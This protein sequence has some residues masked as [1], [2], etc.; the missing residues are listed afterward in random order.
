MSLHFARWRSILIKEQKLQTVGR[1]DP[2]VCAVR[3]CFLSCSSKELNFDLHNPKQDPFWD[4]MDANAASAPG[5]ISSLELMIEAS[6]NSVLDRRFGPAADT[7]DAQIQAAVAA[8][9]DKRLGPTVGSLGNR[10]TSLIEQRLGNAVGIVNHRVEKAIAAALGQRLGPAGSVLTAQI[11]FT[12][13]S[14]SGLPSVQS[15]AQVLGEADEM[16]EDNAICQAAEQ[17]ANAQPV[18]TYGSKEQEAPKEKKNVTELEAYKMP[19]PDSVDEISFHAANSEKSNEPTGKKTWTTHCD[20]HKTA[21]YPLF[22]DSVSKGRNSATEALTAK[23]SRTSQ[24]SS[25]SADQILA[26]RKAKGKDEAN[27]VGAPDE[28]DSL[29]A[30]E[31]ESKNEKPKRKRPKVKLDPPGYTKGPAVKFRRISPK[32]TASTKS[33]GFPRVIELKEFSE[34]SNKENLTM[35]DVVATLLYNYH[36]RSLEA[37]ID[38]DNYPTFRFI[39]KESDRKARN[40]VIERHR[41]SYGVVVKVSGIQLAWSR[42]LIQ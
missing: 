17:L 21:L 13:A 6:V 23:P 9:L 33:R 10:M 12:P 22:A 16:K 7:L 31:E 42:E 3:G 32:L 26:K 25:S 24:R 18:E 11:T 35:A 8:A 19:T 2:A 41:E 38:K 5:L 40:F 4:G 36:P 1:T 28:S 15:E 14:F 20:T 37:F 27:K 34:A 29:S 39:R 30:S